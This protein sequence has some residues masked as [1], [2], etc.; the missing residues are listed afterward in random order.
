[1][2]ASLIQSQGTTDAMAAAF[3]DAAVL[4]AM[5]DVEIALARAEA[6][7]G[8]IPAR[9]A[10]SIARA[11][12]DVAGFDVEGL[13]RVGRESGTVVIPFVKAITE[14]VSAIDEDS[15]RY[16][17]W[18]ATSQ[19]IWDTALVLCMTRAWP[20]VAADHARL[21]DALLQLS[22]RHAGTVMLART[23]LQPASPTTFGLKLAQ[24]LDG[25]DR[26]WHRADAAADAAKVLQLGGAAGTLAALGPAA[27]WVAEDMA[28]SLGLS[29][30]DSSWHTN[31]DVL[32]ALVA[33][34]GIYVAALGKIARDVS[35]LM[36]AEVGE[37]SE[38]GGGSS[39]LP[40]KRN[41]AGAAVILAAASRVPGLV[42]TFL[43]S[44][45]HEHERAVG[46]WHA[47]AP[48]VA[49]VIEAT[50][51]AAAAAANVLTGLTVDTA[52]MRTNLEATRGVMF[53]ERVTFLV[54]N[55]LGR[56]VATRLVTTAVQTTLGS[57][58]TFG[59]VVRATPELADAISRSELATLD[60]PRAY[61][62]SAD[63]FRQAIVARV[64][65]EAKPRP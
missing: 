2:S 62:G 50:G 60:D 63:R 25:A 17:H 29:T 52:R 10:D 39:T 21:R 32:A 15:A 46:G 38:P 13:A 28:A 19:D 47:E 3:S 65:G 8:V 58:R 44:S 20:A 16:V 49:A 9:A 51:A 31:R 23:L 35:L 61:L 40:H 56:D 5:C 57:S 26:A 4:R 37:V 14:R 59:D 12:S 18:G 7:A 36:Q 1:M 11:L 42:A 64:K 45:V 54:A 53:A 6:V 34:C 22:D 24:W 33:S 41:P 48:T 30:S 55:R 43:S 27:A